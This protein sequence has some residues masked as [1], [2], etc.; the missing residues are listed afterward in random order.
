MLNSPSSDTCPLRSLLLRTCVAT[1]HNKKNISYLKGLCLSTP[2]SSHRVS[3]L[4]LSDV[5]WL[6]FSCCVA[7]CDL[8]IAGSHVDQRAGQPWG[9]AQ[10]GLWRYVVVIYNV[11]SSKHGSSPWNC[12]KRAVATV[13][14]SRWGARCWKKRGGGLKMHKYLIILK[15]WTGT[16]CGSVQGHKLVAHAG[17]VPALQRGE[18]GGAAGK[19]DFKVG[20]FC[21]VGRQLELSPVVSQQI[22][23]Q[24]QLVLRFPAGGLCPAEAQHLDLRLHR[25]QLHLSRCWRAGDCGQKRRFTDVWWWFYSTQPRTR[26]HKASENIFPLLPAGE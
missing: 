22:S 10:R 9:G 11:C 17:S 13:Q 23:R 24:R 20:Y 18:V 15:V 1:R 25:R 4:T 19:R 6:T 21:P 14:H 2:P 16:T 5:H 7:G 3:T 26:G 8:Q 12:G